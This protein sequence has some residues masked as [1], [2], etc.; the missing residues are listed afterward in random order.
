MSI[1]R[2]VVVTW[3]EN[4]RKRQMSE[5]R[6][7]WEKAYGPI[8]AG[9]HIHHKDGNAL[10]NNLSNLECIEASAHRDLHGR[11]REEHTRIAG[12]E[13]RKCQH[14]RGWCVLSSFSKRSNGTYQGYCKQ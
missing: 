5:H 13:H 3:R 1:S 12:V 10:N 8:P 14:C 2:R 6:Y 11:M 4:G 9:H 7:V